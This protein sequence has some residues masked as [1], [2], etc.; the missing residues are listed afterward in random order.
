MYKETMCLVQTKMYIKHRETMEHGRRKINRIV[1][2]GE[3][4]SG[5]IKNDGKI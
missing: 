2:R 1:K 5:I 3:N 4:K